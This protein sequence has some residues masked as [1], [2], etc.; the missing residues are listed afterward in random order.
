M[1]NDEQ[2]ELV[3]RLRDEVSAGLLRSTTPV[4]HVAFNFQQWD[5]TPV[6]VFGG[7]L[8]TMVSIETEVSSHTAGGRLY[9]F[10]DLEPML[11][12]DFPYVLLEPEG[13]PDDTRDRIL[14]AGYEPIFANGQGEIFVQSGEVARKVL[15]D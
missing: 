7:M 9:P 12:A 6:G 1:I 10:T 4:L 13:L 14:A 5:A 11:A 3:D 15:S 8:E 2:E